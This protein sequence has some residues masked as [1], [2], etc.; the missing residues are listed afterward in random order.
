[1]TLNF[2]TTAKAFNLVTQTTQ[3]N[4]LTSFT[5]DSIKKILESET[6]PFLVCAEKRFKSRN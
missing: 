5:D 4:H 6:S 3:T 2:C 1:M